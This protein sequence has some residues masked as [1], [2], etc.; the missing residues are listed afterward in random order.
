MTTEENK[1][2]LLE[3][4]Q[5]LSF[6]RREIILASGRRSNFY[7]D[8]KQTALTPEGLFLIGNIFLNLISEIGEKVDGVAG[9]T[10]GG[11]PL[12]CA[13]SYASYISGNKLPALIIRKELKG[14]GTE[15][16]VEGKKNVP[17]KAKVVIL[18][19]V[20]TT[21]GSTLKACERVKQEGLEVGYIICLVDREEGGREN[22]EGAGYR[23]YSVFRKRDFISDE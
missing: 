12:V 6:Q 7:I 19:D 14:H 21:G 20:V 1:K 23:L 18:E 3:L 4:L 8:C 22:I 16:Y 13:T 2:R 10:L 11:D 15:V 17:D 9:V 5:T